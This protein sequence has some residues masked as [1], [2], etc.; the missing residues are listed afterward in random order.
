MP[1][2]ELQARALGCAKQLARLP[3][4]TFVRTRALYRQAHFNTLEGQMELE[5][6]QQLVCFAGAEVSEALSAV[7]ERR[8]PDFTKL[9][10]V[11]DDV[12]RPATAPRS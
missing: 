5:R 4:Q 8:E 1:D 6:Q 9:N 10:S 3:M 7:R 11:T 2:T 12:A